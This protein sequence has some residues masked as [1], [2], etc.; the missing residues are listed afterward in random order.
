MKPVLKGIYRTCAC[1]GRVIA[2]V[3][4]KINKQGIRVTPD[5]GQDQTLRMADIERMPVVQAPGLC[6]G[7]GIHV[8]REVENPR[9]R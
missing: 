1:G 8:A 7:L 2:V 9:L 3:T 6:V 5:L 4:Y